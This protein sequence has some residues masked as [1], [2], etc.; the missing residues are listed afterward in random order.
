[1]LISHSNKFIFVHIQKTGGSTV[2]HILQ[3]QVSD[4]EFLG[5]RHNF[6]MNEID[7]VNE[8]KDYYKFAFV[9]NP[10]G[11]LVSWFS[12]Y[13]EAR[14]VTWY[15]RLTSKRAQNLY[16][17]TRKYW[18]W[19]YVHEHGKTFDDF[20]LKCTGVIGSKMP[21]G[22]S[23]ISFNQLDYIADKEGNLL[24][25]FVGRFENFQEDFRHAGQQINVDLSNIPWTNRTKHKHYSEYYT[26]ETRAV[27]DEIYQRDIEFF[28][29]KFETH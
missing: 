3:T 22:L 10:W 8:C 17:L 13:D 16:Q 26:P 28:G 19:Q 6:V 20:I 11:R 1:M 4:T 23:P 25:D 5:H 7:T 18:F 2:E 29:Y 24:V 15:D 14:R 27:V 21:G 9:R 12:M